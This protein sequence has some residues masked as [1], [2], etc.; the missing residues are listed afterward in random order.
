MSIQPVTLCRFTAAPHPD[1]RVGLVDAG[2]VRDLTAA[3]VH[4]LD[5]LLEQADI[6]GQVARA[7]RM[8]LPEWPLDQVRL[9]TPVES[10]EV[11]AAGVTHLRRK[12]TRMGEAGVR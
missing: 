3:G 10:Q 9:L 11:W 1:V 6:D 12:Q 4:R 2:S 8:A 7:R 5:D